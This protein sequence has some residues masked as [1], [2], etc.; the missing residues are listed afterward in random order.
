MNPAFEAAPLSS[1]LSKEANG[2]ANG[3]GPGRPSGYPFGLT[4]RQVAKIVARYENNESIT[5]LSKDFFGDA[6]AKY[7]QRIRKVLLKNGVELRYH[8]RQALAG[9]KG[10][11]AAGKKFAKKTAKAAKTEKA[12]VARP[13]S[14]KRLTEGDVINDALRT[15]LRRQADD[16]ANYLLFGDLTGAQ[17]QLS[18]IKQ[19]LAVL[20]ERLPA[21]QT[22]E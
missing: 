12:A 5:S 17:T 19:T 4:D 2:R 9:R 6:G 14:A 16:L 8:P 13:I 3:H 11:L 22:G 20:T 10:G 21:D 7:F 15:Q 18:L 1:F